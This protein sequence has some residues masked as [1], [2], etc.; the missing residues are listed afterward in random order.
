MTPVL[1]LN[2]R[3]VK[4]KSQVFGKLVLQ[5]ESS[6]YVEEVWFDLKLLRLLSLSGTVF[7]PKVHDWSLDWEDGY[8][9]KWFGTLTLYVSSSFEINEEDAIYAANCAISELNIVINEIETNV[10]VMK[11]NDFSIDWTDVCQ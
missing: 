7:F 4:V 11:V 3:K 2:E 8:E 1:I 5:V 9:D 6:V 10:G